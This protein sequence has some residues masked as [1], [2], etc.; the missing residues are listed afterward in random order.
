M[1]YVFRS[2]PL[3][4]EHAR[5]LLE[6]CH[7]PGEEVL[8]ASL[9]TECDIL[10]HSSDDYHEALAEGLESLLRR[11]P[12][13]DPEAVSAAEDLLREAREPIT[14]KI[15]ELTWPWDTHSA[16][17]LTILRECLGA[18]LA[19]AALHAFSEKLALFPARGGE[20]LGDLLLSGCCTLRRD[21]AAPE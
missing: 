3:A 7:A 6:T 9:D 11:F 21:S 14:D 19:S 8:L 16:S 1:L 17:V 12:G 20:I 10:L 15:T 4:R 18:D 5:H 2:T 13:A